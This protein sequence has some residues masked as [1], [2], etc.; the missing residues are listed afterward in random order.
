MP[1][2]AKQAP[3]T[4]TTVTTGAF[5]QEGLFLVRD[6]QRRKIAE[7]DAGDEADDGMLQ[8]S[9]Q[10]GGERERAAGGDAEDAEGDDRGHRVVEGGLAHH[11]LGDA[12]AD[13]DLAEDSAPA[14]PDRS[15]LNVA[16]S[17]SATISGM[18]R[19]SCAASAGDRSRHH[20]AGDG[21]DDESMV[22][23]TRFST[24]SRSA[25]PPSNRM[26]LA[27]NSRMIWFSANRR[28]GARDRA[29]AGRS[30]CR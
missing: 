14:P 26:K 6:Q 3:M 12:V 5:G 7:H 17:K 4:A 8:Q 18:L 24:A 19:M 30:R 29:R 25:A 27:P 22:I 1:S 15:S 9:E 11:G 2:A 10:R 21:R 16:A 13:A 20:D 23:Q 28:R